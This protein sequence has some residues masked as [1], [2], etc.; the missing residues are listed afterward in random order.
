MGRIDVENVLEYD[1]HPKVMSCG[2]VIYRRNNTNDT[3]IYLLIK[4]H[5]KYGNNWDFPKGNRE[6]EETEEETAIRET[7]EETGL[8]VDLIFG[9][10]SEI[11][12]LVNNKK[13]LKT[14]VYFLSE[15]KITQVKIDPYEIE[16]YE[17]LDYEAA[18]LRL[19]HNPVKTILTKAHNF[20]ENNKNV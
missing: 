16:Q 20:I 11:H 8:K 5:H 14:S 9:F 19:T 17:W 2:S 15:T 7:F 12:Y 6:K 3:I 4:N 1:A 18:L 10:R 13:I